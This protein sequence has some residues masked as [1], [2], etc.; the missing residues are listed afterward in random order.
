MTADLS[1]LASFNHLTLS[2]WSDRQSDTGDILTLDIQ[3]QTDPDKI[4]YF[5]LFTV[6]LNHIEPIYLWES[7]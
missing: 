3:G 6:V 1:L 2:L 7:Q 4:N 5:L